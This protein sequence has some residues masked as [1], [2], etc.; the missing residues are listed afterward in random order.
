[1]AFS[2]QTAILLVAIGFAVGAFG[3]VVGAGGGFILTPILL[4]LYP[5][6]SAQTLTAI[7]LTAVFFNAASGSAAYARQRRIDY[8]SGGI[9]ALATIPGAIGGA[10]L[11]GVV[12]RQVFDAIM[13][14][15]LAALAVWLIAG[16]RWPLGAA[17]GHL[18]RRLIVDR[19]GETYEYSVPV[20]RGAVYSLGVGFL[21]SFLGIGGGV[22]HVP[23][24]VRALGF[25]THIATA[26]SHFV[27][28]IMAGTGTITHLVIGSFH[29]HGFR[30]TVALSIGV[31]AGAQLGA[32]ISLRLHGRVIHW[33]LAVALLAL[34]ARL[35]VGAG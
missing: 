25:P 1:L 14:V 12:S 18:E 10:L 23:L 24:L 21:S 13:G 29:H 5:H 11:V 16:E 28:A 3:T 20:I 34:S 22:I 19:A 6:E 7:S 35:L 32:R 9:F 17:R 2:A 27:L 4:L 26:T 33:L 15:V 31:V 30:R 8:R